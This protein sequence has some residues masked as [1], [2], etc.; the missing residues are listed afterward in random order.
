MRKANWAGAAILVGV[1]GIVVGQSP[2]PET[3][4]KGDVPAP[5]QSKEP[6]RF[7]AGL[8]NLPNSLNERIAAVTKLPPAD[9][10]K[11]MEALGPAIR[12]LLGQGQTVAVPNLG[13]FRVVRIPEHRDLV[14]GRPATIGG[15]NYV[16]FLPT[17]SFAAAAELPGVQPAETVPPFQYNP[18]PD[19]APGLKTGQTR[20]PNS[21]TP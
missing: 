18:L 14:N 16:E 17:G 20:S 21:R 13:R 15:S 11:V 2:A 19:Q 3:S 5:Q 1:A 8:P 6:V 7:G 9:V 10:V 12:D 4:K